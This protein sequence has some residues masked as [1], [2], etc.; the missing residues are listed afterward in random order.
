MAPQ[1][2]D[3]TEELDH[4]TFIGGADY[5]IYSKDNSGKFQIYT[6]V[7]H[8]NRDSYYGGLGGGRTEQDSI[9]ANN[10]FGKTKD[11]AWV[12]GIQYTKKLKNRDVLTVGTEFNKTSTQ[13]Q[14]A[15][16]NRLIDQTVNSFG[17]YAQYEWKPSEKFTALVGARLDNVSVDGEFSI[18]GI[19]RIADVNQ[20][21][22]SPRITLSY[23]FNDA[24]KFRGGYARGFRAAQ[25]FNE[26]L[27]ISSVGGEAQYPRADHV[28]VNF[29]YFL[30][31][32]R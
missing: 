23:Q 8:T 25:A 28:N 20:T 24:L 15:G 31:A 13:D 16:Y 22:F 12:N 1:F 32:K 17:T 9:L 3:I 27:H 7:S 30:F 19:N 18:G 10:A 26:D 21:A 14:I 2:T 29:L 5:E 11:V 6:S 4:D